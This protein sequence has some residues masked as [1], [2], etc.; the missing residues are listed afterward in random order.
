MIKNSEL[1][2]DKKILEGAEKVWGRS[3]EAGKRR[4][5]RRAEMVIEYCGIDSGKR[6]LE[7]GCGTGTLTESLVATGAE[8]VATDIF[9]DFLKVVEGKIGQNKN[10]SFRIV[11]AETL[12]GFVDESFDAV[13]G[14]SI[15]H[16]LDIDKT[17]AAIKR[18]LKPGGKLAF[19]E[20]NMMNP[21]IVV[22]KN[23]PPIKKMM[24]DSPEETAFFR[25]PL[26]NK[27]K[28]L[29]FSEINIVPFDFLHPSVPN[30]LAPLVDKLGFLIE[31]LPLREIAGSLFIGAKK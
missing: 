29:G 21:Q 25:W 3:G 11:D 19:A 10:V 17:F 12:D 30:F 26:A 4:L 24:G 31:K 6:V 20:P 23:I 1:E 9:E 15:L 22:Q 13:V 5:K 14:L 18:V 16:H 2:H 7:I 27:L 8:L 28:G